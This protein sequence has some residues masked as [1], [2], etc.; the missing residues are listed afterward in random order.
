MTVGG[1]RKKE[2]G[3]KSL[4]LGKESALTRTREGGKGASSFF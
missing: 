1:E 4:L 3:E 2:E